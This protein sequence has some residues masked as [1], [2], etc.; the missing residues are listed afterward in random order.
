MLDKAF[1][2]AGTFIRIYECLIFIS[3]ICGVEPPG[4]HR[5]GMI[6]HAP[7][8]ALRNYERRYPPIDLVGRE[9]WSSLFLQRGS[10]TE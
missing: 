10:W 9:L 7:A 4:T 5:P 6:V 3:L 8:G 2:R 1:E